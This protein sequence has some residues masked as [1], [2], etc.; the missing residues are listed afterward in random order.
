MAAPAPAAPAPAA[1]PAPPPAPAAA[2]TR[3]AV[4]I[5]TAPADVT[6]VVSFPELSVIGN[7]GISTLSPAAIFESAVFPAAGALWKVVVMPNNNHGALFALRLASPN[8]T[9]TPER[10]VFKLSGATLAPTTELPRITFST[11]EPPP[12]GAVVRSNFDFAVKHHFLFTGVGARSRPLQTDG[13][14]SIDVCMRAATAAAEAAT[15]R[16]EHS[17]KAQVA[18]MR[19]KGV[20]CD[21]TFTFAAPAG[22]AAPQP[23]RAHSFILAARSGMFFDMMSQGL[24]PCSDPLQVRE[25][26]SV[27]AFETFLHFLYKDMKFVPSMSKRLLMEL[28]EASEFYRVPKLL[29]QCEQA[30]AAKLTPANM[31]RILKMADSNQARTTLRDAALRYVADHF[32]LIADSADWTALMH[33]HPRLATDVTLTLSSHG[34]PPEWKPADK[35]PGEAGDDAAAAPKRPRGG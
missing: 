19:T 1:E 22:Q 11:V 10:V 31:L 17:L 4:A 13:I 2:P 18:A 16:Y 21:V 25:G 27:E 33:E 8:R 23:V 9:I 34:Q 29:S 26:M 12:P 24:L 3:T 5:S 14:L 20:G 28:L 35:R 6:A 15:W 30:L 32:Q 7:A